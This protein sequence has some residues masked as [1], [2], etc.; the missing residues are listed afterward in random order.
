M[1]K[2]LQRGGFNND[3]QPV[4]YWMTMMLINYQTL[5]FYNND[6]TQQDSGYQ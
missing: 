2:K 4:K 5:D 3:N 6:K 1:T